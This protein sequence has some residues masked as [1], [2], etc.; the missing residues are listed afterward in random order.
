MGGDWLFL[1]IGI[2]VVAAL[3]LTGLL[4]T[5]RR[6]LPPPSDA[7]DV[8]QVDISTQAAAPAPAPPVEAPPVETLPVEPEVAAPTVEIPEG[9]VS[10]LVKLR[11]RLS[12]SQG[13]LG[14]GLL[15]LLS[16][17]RIDEDTWEDIEDTLLTADIGVTPTQ[18]LVA[19]LRTRLRVEGEK[20]R[21]PRPSCTRNWSRSST[22]PWTGDSR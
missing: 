9:R 15:A 10:R 4:V 13:A 14:R 18:E 20:A 5:G 17:D 11:E 6:R 8:E 22:R 21:T 7:T 12:R 3:T 1:I 19:S 2:A 16:R